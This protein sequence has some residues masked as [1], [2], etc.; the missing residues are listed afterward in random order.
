MTSEIE[1]KTAVI[2]GNAGPMFIRERGK[3][4]A[5]KIRILHPCAN[6]L[7]SRALRRGILCSND[8]ICSDA[9]QNNG[10]PYSCCLAFYWF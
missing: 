4:S 6:A 1:N 5:R 2:L 9:Q 10:F 7:I 3:K 8:F